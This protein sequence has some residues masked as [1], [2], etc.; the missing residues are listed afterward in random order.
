M[1]ALQACVNLTTETALVRV[2]LPRSQSDPQQV[3]AFGEKLAKVRTL[4][5]EIQHGTV[6]ECAA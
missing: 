2:L 6:V 4:T 1:L 5:S 3:Y